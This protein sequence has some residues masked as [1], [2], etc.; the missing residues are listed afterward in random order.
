MGF[1]RKLCINE[2]KIRLKL[3]TKKEDDLK[4]K[5]YWSKLLNINI[6]SFNKSTEP[7]GKKDKSIYLHGTL[8]VRYNSKKLLEKLNERAERMIFKRQVVI[9]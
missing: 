1:L 2:D 5:I 6:N 7:N 9:H 4:N 3:K 8:T